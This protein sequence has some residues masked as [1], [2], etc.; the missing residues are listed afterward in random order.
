MNQQAKQQ[1]QPIYMSNTNANTSQPT[2][3]SKTAYHHAATM[4]VDLAEMAS[5]GTAMKI[6]VNMNN[7]R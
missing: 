1:I 5:F 6:S 4:T 7:K 2:F 3:Y